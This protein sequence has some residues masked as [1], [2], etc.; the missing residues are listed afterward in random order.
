MLEIFSFIFAFEEMKECCWR[1]DTFFIL[2]SLA[3]FLPF[4]FF[5]SL[6]SVPVRFCLDLQGFY[7]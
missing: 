6:H 1:F 4:F 2:D 7:L 5:S 3:F